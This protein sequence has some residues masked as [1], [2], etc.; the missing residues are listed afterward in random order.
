MGLSNL[1]KNCT[2]TNA[3]NK[4]NRQPRKEIIYESCTW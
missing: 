2:S 3:I 4:V 1:K